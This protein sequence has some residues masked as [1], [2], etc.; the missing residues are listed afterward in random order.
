MRH[1]G[2]TG[3]IGSGKSTVTQ[4]WVRCGA[5]AVDADQLSRDLTRAGGAAIPLIQAAFGESAI[6]SDGALDRARM[7]ERVF[8]DPS[9]KA[10]LEGI[11]HPMIRQASSR[12]VELARLSGTQVLVHDI[13]LLVES[14]RHKSDKSDKSDKGN[15]GDKAHQHHNENL[16]PFDRILV[17]DCSPETQVSRVMAR[18]GMARSEVLRIMQA[19]ASREARLAAAD[20][21]LLNEGK[22]LAELEREVQALYQRAVEEA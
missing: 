6:G 14:G 20:W 8:G 12:L 15:E 17:V 19:Q 7:R 22:T 11:L 2:I 13:P 21:V 5:Q 18:S 16:S 3:G 4:M 10:L 9:A 1:I